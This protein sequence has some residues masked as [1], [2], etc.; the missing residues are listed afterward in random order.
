MIIAGL[1]F[2]LVMYSTLVAT[3]PF[4]QFWAVFLFVT[5]IFLGLDT[6]FATVEVVRLTLQRLV[7]QCCGLPSGFVRGSTRGSTK[8]SIKGSG[9][10]VPDVV[11]ICMCLSCFL[12]AI[13][14]I[15][16]GGIYLMHLTDYYVCT[17]AI[18]LLALIMAASV[19]ILYG[20]GRLARNVREMT[21]HNPS[22]F[23]VACW[24][25]IAPV[26]ILAVWIFHAVDNSARS[27]TMNH[28]QYVFP[29]WT[30]GLGS[31]VLA[32][33]LAAIPILA[34]LAIYEASG[35][36]LLRVSFS[37]LGLT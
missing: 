32:L 23:L 34:G 15:T 33:I 12:G 22:P 26:L 9:S 28:G 14:Y 35:K 30:I 16:Q 11:S 1:S 17:L 21:S 24:A 2:S 18:T 20:A 29:A 6:Q 3:M 4:P 19:G 5:I 13:L 8:G 7:K 31:A 36:T 10:W 37:T 27:L 25:A